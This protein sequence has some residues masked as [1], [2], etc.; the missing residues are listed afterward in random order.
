M[1]CNDNEVETLEEVRRIVERASLPPFQRRDM[2][3]AVKRICEMAGMAPATVVAEPVALRAMISK[4]LPAAHGVGRKTWS[5][6][7]SG[8]RA[9]L[10]LAGVIDPALQG[11][12]SRHPAWAPLAQAIAGDKRLSSGLA[13]FQNW[14]AV[15]GPTPDDVDNA[16]VRRF[17]V[18]LEHRTLRRKPRDIVRSI[19]KLW[20]EASKRIEIWPKTALAP[21]S[22]KAPPK[23]RQWCE[24]TESFRRDAEAYLAMRANPDPFD[25]NPNAPKR[26]L[27][28]S[29]LWQQREHLRLAASI[30]IE[31]GTVED[32]KSL[33]DLVEPEAFK[34]VLRYYHERA[35]RKPNAF[36]IVMAKTLIQVA[37]FHVGAAPD[38]VARLKRIAAMLP[39]IPF[40]LTAKNRA[41]LR[42]LESPRLRAKLLFLPEELMA[43]VVK[44][45]ERGRLA[46]VKAQMA[47]AIDLGLSVA[48][49][50]Q[51]LSSLHWQRHFSEPDGPKGRLVL[52]LPAEETKSRRQEFIAEIPDDVA[53]RL[54][55]YRRNILP[56]LNADVNGFLFVTE[57]GGPK[58]QETLS[59]QITQV[60]AQRVGIHMTPHQPRHFCGSSYLE[61]HPDDLETARLMLGHSS[62]KTTRIYVG[63]DGRRASQVYG[64]FLFKQRDALKLKRK[65]EPKPKPKKK[66]SEDQPCDH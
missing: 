37:Q 5:N 6:L 65:L 19:P 62:S 22:F 1:N 21:I 15:S 4:I 39:P 7:L 23:R 46:L 27:A 32:I 18:W 50:P 45:L 31:S 13:P 61:E 29:T 20:N 59:Q 63:S 25:E 44:D 48:P 30:L 28:K 55:W 3:S 10:R 12:A 2:L 35:N 52:R 41:L 9:A 42:Q 53:R 17:H 57:K 36:V 47:I 66:E 8:L 64:D 38:E 56:C 51:N 11:D 60:I 54:R 24:L 43:E 34:C 58:S 16:V 14:C 49:R 26:P 40:D 33:A